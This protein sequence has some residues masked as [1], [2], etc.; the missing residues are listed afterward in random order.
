MNDWLKKYSAEND[1]I[2]LD[3]YSAT[4][5]EKKTLKDGLSYDGLHPNADGYKVMRQ[6]A[7]KAIARALKK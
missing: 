4:V 2:Y 1:L 6:A 7:E 3:Y 5:D